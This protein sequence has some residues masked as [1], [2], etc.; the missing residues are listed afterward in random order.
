M[1][2]IAELTSKPTGAKRAA[3][4]LRWGKMTA[5][6][7]L[8]PALVL[9]LVFFVA[10]FFYSLYLSFHRWNM[11][12]PTKTFVGMSNYVSLLKSEVFWKAIW[13]TVLY[14]LY[15]VP[16][17]IL[18]GFLL[19]LLI[20]NIWRGKQMYRLVFYLPVVSSISIISIVWDLMY[21]PDIGMVNRLLSFVGLKGGNWLNDPKLALGALAV[22]GIWKHFGYNMI[23][24]ISGRKAID[25]SLYEAASIDGASRLQ[26]MVYVTIPLLSPVTFFI[27]VMNIL[28][29]F[30][31]F[32]TIQITTHGGPNN[33]T[34]VIVY[35][36][37]QEAFQ[38][39]DIG[40]AAASS[41]MFLIAVGALTVLQLKI[42]Q[43]VVHYQ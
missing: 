7:F 13:N 31:V 11:I 6:W 3:R 25:R 23:L 19:A 15:T 10:P 36:I 12:S 5:Y 20:E 9:Y 26:Q 35:Q 38:F 39:F 4:R 16:L 41:T 32:A 1:E 43:K 33:A 29:S 2:H 18:I 8:L 30:Q 34:N 22:I 27:V 37:Y 21:N 14:V 28:S 40:A 42:G 17:S 24:Y